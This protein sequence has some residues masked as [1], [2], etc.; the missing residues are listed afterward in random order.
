MQPAAQPSDRIDGDVRGGDK[1][2]ERANAIRAHFLATGLSGAATEQIEEGINGFVAKG[3][4][5][6]AG[7]MRRVEEIDRRACR[8]IVEERFHVRRMVQD[9]IRLYERVRDRETW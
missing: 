1:A 9:Y 4:R 3:V 2:E 6:L 5:E 7:Y 8:A